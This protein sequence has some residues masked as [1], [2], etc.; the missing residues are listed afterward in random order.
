MR[1]TRNFLEVK[2]Y[3]SFTLLKAAPPGRGSYG[4]RLLLRKVLAT[5][6]LTVPFQVR[7]HAWGGSQVGRRACA[8]L[9]SDFPLFDGARRVACHMDRCAF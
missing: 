2:H 5:H 1:F 6:P 9:G 8:T 3:V 7:A 4:S